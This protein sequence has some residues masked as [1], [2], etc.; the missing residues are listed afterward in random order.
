MNNDS[1]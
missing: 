1:N